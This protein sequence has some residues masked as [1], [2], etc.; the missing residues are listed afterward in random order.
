MK[1]FYLF[2]LF[3][4][5][6]AFGQSQAG[7]WYFG[8]RAGVSFNSGVL[9]VTLTNGELDTYEGTA[10]LCDV[11]GNLLF[12]T[13]GRKIWNKNHIVMP[14]GAGLLGDSSSTQS[15][16]IVPKPASNNLFY[17][18]TVDFLA[19]QNGLNYNI[20]DIN[21]NGGLGDVISK[22]NLL[23]A[24]TLE[25]ITV[26]KHANKVNYW[27]ISHKYD[28]NEFVAFELTP[29]GINP[30][31]S[32]NVGVTIQPIPTQTV[33]Y[34]KSSPNGELVACANSENSN[35]IQLFRFDNTTGKLT[36]ISTSNFSG[37]PIGAY[38][39]EF[40]P[41]NKLLYVSRIDSNNDSSQIYQFNIANLDETSI[42]N[43]KL[44]IAN[45]V[46]PT[47]TGIFAALQLAPNQKIYVARNNSSFLGV[48]NNPNSLGLACS[49]NANAVDL[50]PKKS[51]Y[52]L[53]AFITS[54]FNINIASSKFCLGD[55]TQFNI[56]NYDAILSAL[57]DFGDVNSPNNSSS[58]QNA[59]HIFSSVGTYTV[60][61]TVQTAT[62]PNVFTDE[63]K[64]VNKPIANQPIDFEL[65]EVDS[66]SALFDL[67]TKNN[68]ILGIQ[69]A[70]DY[71]ISYHL[72]ID[73]ANNNVN[74]LVTNYPNT[75]NPQTIYAR[76][77]TISAS[78]CFD[79]TS[80]KLI[81][82]AKPK[83]NV[84]KDIPYCLENYP[85]FITLSAEKLL[86]T[87]ILTYKW[88]NGLETESIQVNQPNIY[89]VTATN[90]SGCKSI[91][92]L[93]VFNSEIAKIKYKIEGNIGN[94]SLIVTTSG[95][96]NYVYSL[97]EINGSYQSSPVF[98]NLLP[99]NHIIYVKDVNGCGVANEDFYV[100]GYP[101]YFTPNNDGIHDTWNLAD[102][103]KE[104]KSLSIFDRY[105]KL[106]AVLNPNSSNWNGKYQEKELPSSDYWFKLILKDDSIENGHFSLKR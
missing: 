68:E 80:F 92:T 40:S 25:K 76:I 71:K 96:G 51:Y 60:S 37:N 46:S 97:D 44:L 29:T 106:L 18:F 101:K 95:I 7:I 36:L 94:Y 11:S 43:S 32:S 52:G 75:S 2:I 14:N 22:N 78:T 39:V 5:Q 79:V 48:I 42:N 50:S 26:V 20:V 67:S 85:D 55:Q 72:N 19:R 64:I 21:L 93:K 17:V 105:G 1:L 73:D 91:R 86:P 103:F 6:L 54:L 35:S 12:Y 59:T 9:P 47:K 34:L 13:D 69:L 4:V 90:A 100:I 56:P 23:I 62:G 104:Y 99:G 70:S 27:I 87:E 84:D 53:P 49:F 81:A 63:I 74:P 89:S 88:S 10:T 16:I 98:N 83:L 82:N 66:S 31:V 45:F 57:W 30:P 24:P 65:C 102:N 28:G 15:A 8:E 33:G 58:D 38:G 41:N 61:L 3:T 77:Q